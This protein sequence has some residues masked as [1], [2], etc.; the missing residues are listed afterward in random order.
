MKNTF[1]GSII[2]FTIM[3]FYPTIASAR[4]QWSLGFLVGAPSLIAHLSIPTGEN[5]RLD[6]DLGWSRWDVTNSESNGQT[7]IHTADIIA[8]NP[9]LMAS[10]VKFLSGLGIALGYWMQ[11][12]IDR[13]NGFF[14][15][16]RLPLGFETLS[17]NSFKSFFKISPGLLF[18]PNLSFRMDIGLGLLY[19][20]S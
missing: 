11:D 3:I 12:K 7:F 13:A 15:G 5:I 17:L 4:S 16:F 8:W 18:Y 14:V 10:N 1:S 20:F 6:L 9:S 19:T 2:L